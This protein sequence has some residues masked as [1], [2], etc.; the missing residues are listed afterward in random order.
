M[1]FA[2]RQSSAVMD[3]LAHIPSGYSYVKYFDFRLN[4]EHPPLIKAIAALP[5]LFYDLKFPTE[6]TAWTTAI[7]GQWDMGR[8]FLYGSGNDPDLIV[9]V[10]RLGPMLL[11]ILLLILV[12]VW[13]R[14]LMGPLWALL[15]TLMLG[16][17]PSFLAHGEYVTTDVGAALG[18]ILGT[19]FFVKML[20]AP[21]WKSLLAGSIAFG[22]AELMKFS[23]VLLIPLFGFLAVVYALFLREQFGWKNRLRAVLK[24]VLRTIAV[25]AIGYVLIVYPVY[26]LFTAKYPI[27][28][29]V[30][31]TTYILRSFAEGPTP[32]GQVC[33]PVRCIADLNIWMS[34][35]AV[36]RPL[37]EYMIGVLMVV[38]RAAGGNTNYFL[39]T[40]SN[41]GSRW[42]FP[43]VY[44]L[45]EPIPILILVLSWLIT[46]LVRNTKTLWKYGRRTGVIFVDYLK[47]HFT[48]FS[49]ASFVVL[50]WVYSMKSPLNIGFRHL[51]PSLPLLYILAANFWRKSVAN[52]E[53][54]YAESRL[55]VFWSFIRSFARASLRGSFIFAL[56]LW[57]VFET[58]MIA[59]NFLSYFNQFGKGTWGGYRYV[60]DSNYDWGQDLL[61]LKRWADLRPEVKKIALDYFGGGDPAYYLGG[62]TESWWSSRGNPKD[63][64]I[65]WFAVS[66]NSIQ[67]SIQPVVSTNGF[68][69]NPAD[70]YSWL[71]KGRKWE[72]GLG[73]A[74]VPDYRAGTSIFIYKL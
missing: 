61:N 59:P 54:P 47:N 69:R 40:V 22:I 7:N 52:I 41:E 8:A 70:E 2:S 18:I 71:T 28:R 74:P 6:I 67:G 16:F 1:L 4:P 26:F 33:K 11:F 45:K 24:D 57:L 9:R 68:V 21:S 43:V 64:G 73:G 62:R 35:N 31:D 50:Y 58:I 53:I 13:S 63:A 49:I 66:I 5:L 42:Y 29:Q 3:E 56:M 10:S 32:Q 20:R 39:G 60:T 34:K 30:A 37:A 72:P 12:Y 14:E 25:F 38:Q 23:A 36:T 44:L 19:Y 48:E 27:D 15:P 55:Q 46:T 51:F 17:S 65:E